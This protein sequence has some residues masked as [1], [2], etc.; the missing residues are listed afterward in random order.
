MGALIL[1]SGAND[2]GKS[3]WAEELLRP[4]SGEKYYIATMVPQ[5][6]DNHLRIEK[7]RRQ[8]EGIGF[9]TLE[10]P[11]GIDR[12][13]VS[14]ESAVLL[15]DVS[16]LLGNAIFSQGKTWENVYQELMR[17]R[18]GCT[19]LCAVTISG[20]LPEDYG[21]ET[22]AYIR[23]LNA[24]NDRLTAAADAA[25][26]MHDGRPVPVKGEVRGVI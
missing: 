8:R 16:N 19:L 1:I 4:F 3:R 12:A 18:D 9:R 11:C 25:V 10:L 5:T 26:K 24:L 14:P 21:G 13:P 7:H 22:A 17:L 20:L 2:S 23:D 6:E 15:E